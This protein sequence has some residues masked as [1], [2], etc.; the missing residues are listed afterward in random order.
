MCLARRTGSFTQGSSWLGLTA[1]TVDFCASVGGCDLYIPSGVTLNTESLNGVLNIQ[2]NVI[3]VTSGGIFQLGTTGVAGGFSFFYQ[4]IFI[5]YGQLGYVSSDNTGIRIPFGSSF[6]LFSGASISTT[7]SISLLVYNPTTNA[8][9]GS[10][11]SLQNGVSQGLFVEVSSTGVIKQNTVYTFTAAASGS[12]SSSLTWVGGVLPSG[13]CFIRIPANVVVTFTG[14][15][16][17]VNIQVLTIDGT[18]TVESTG[19]VGF[20][21]AYAINIMINAGGTFQD[22]TDINQIYCQ[23]D[24]LFTFLVGSLFVGSNTQVFSYNGVSP[25]GSVVDSVVLGP[26]K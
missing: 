7:V 14:A 2:F 23:P 10:G 20:A 13:N 16:L 1:P 12:F 18:F 8:I 15:V 24:T 17:N 25:S 9:V 3:T 22:Q 19:G 4:F 26:F 21:F 5:I 6:N 11:V